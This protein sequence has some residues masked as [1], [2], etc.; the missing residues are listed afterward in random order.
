MKRMSGSDATDKACEINHS[1]Y[2]L[3]DLSC[4]QGSGLYAL[5]T[6]GLRRLA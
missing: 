5:R 2:R 3:L 4:C 1:E 6:E